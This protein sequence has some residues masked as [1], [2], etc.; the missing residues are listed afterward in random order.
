MIVVETKDPVR[1]SNVTAE[2]KKARRTKTGNRLQ[3]ALRKA[4]E[5]G[6]LQAGKNLLLGQ[7]G[8]G[9]GTGTG[10]GTGTAEFNPPTPTPTEPTKMKP[11]LKWGLIIGGIA[12]VGTIVY[13]VLKKKVK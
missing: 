11:A 6:L 8:A 2:E 1:Y 12:V 3:G 13:M 4:D 7:G 9:T 5:S 10:A